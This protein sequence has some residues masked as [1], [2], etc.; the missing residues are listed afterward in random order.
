GRLAWGRCQRPSQAERWLARLRGEEA[1]ADVVVHEAAGLHEGVA[2]GGA[3][4]AEATGS[5][6]GA[7]RVG[8]GRGGGDVG[9]RAGAA[10]L[11]SAPDEAPYTLVDRPVL[12]LHRED[13]PCVLH[14]RVDLRPVA[15]DARVSQQPAAARGVEAGHPRRIKPGERL[16]VVLPLAEDGLPR[17]ASL[18]ALQDQELVEHTVVVLGPPPL[19]VVVAHHQRVLARPG[20][21]P[22]GLRG[23]QWETPA[24]VPPSMFLVLQS[25]E[26]SMVSGSMPSRVSVSRSGKPVSARP[27]LRWN[28]RIEAP[29]CV[30]GGASAA[31]NPLPRNP[32]ARW[33]REVGASESK[34]GSCAAPG[35]W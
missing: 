27:W 3:H 16:P 33:E 2:D 22:S 26:L 23:V 25:S 30:P 6:R 29:S 32:S 35:P 5:Q 15:H 24:E 28:P 9:Q 14:R 11:A 7:E 8:L 1:G 21:A 12:L 34:G 13:Q 19:P 31:R 4:E 17:Q 20:A 10:E 18:R